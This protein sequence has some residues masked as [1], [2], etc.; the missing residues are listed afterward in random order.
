MGIK[1]IKN[2]LF[3]EQISAVKLAELCDTPT[4]VYSKK[5][6]LNNF[7]SYKKAFN[8]D[9]VC[10]AVKA[11]SNQTLLEILSN[12]GAGA[13]IVSGGELFKVLRAG[14]NPQKIVYSG[15]GKTAEEIKYALESNILMFN[16]ESYEEL[17]AINK[18]AK[19]MNK[20]AR[21]AFRVNPNVDP[22]TH[23]YI[24]TGKHGTKF[25]I[26]YEDAIDMYI[27]ASKMANIEIIGI[28]THIGSQILKIEPY[29]LAALKISKLIDKLESL[30][31]HLKY[32]DIGGGLGIKYE[33]N[34]KP[35][36]PI[37]LKK[38]VMSVFGKYKDKTL[39][40][41]PGRSIIGNTGVM[42]GKVIYRK[43]SGNKNFLIV[44][45]GMNDLIRP[46]LYDAYHNILPVKKT[47]KK[48]ITLDIVG[49]ICES[50]DFIAK[51]RKFP[52][53]EQGDLIAVECIGAYGSAMSSQYNSRKRSRGII[54]DGKKVIH[55]RRRDEFEDLLR[56]E[57]N[58][59][60]YL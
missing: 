46:T 27:S 3:I 2:E 30:N 59:E 10:Y 7:N 48:P 55:I 53:L 47:S 40:V 52:L 17:C 60:K 44:D 13:D 20:K 51:D 36:K 23:K 1:Y 31:I 58:L 11:N 14:I 15:V 26:K 4:Y 42:L 54:V 19:Q 33:K 38:A 16:V 28:D 57:E 9:I 49:P 37:E 39:I 43:K 34:Q 25:G 12:L 5:L 35:P 29:K 24:A 56:L 8:N 6:I 32:I 50:G 45:I 41:E 22:D 18:I 21:I